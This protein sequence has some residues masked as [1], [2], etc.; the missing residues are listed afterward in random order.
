MMQY[1]VMVDLIRREARIYMPDGTP[2]LS[3][4][5]L[6]EEGDE[7][8]LTLMERADET[9][10][11]K[12]QDLQVAEVMMM[13]Q[14]GDDVETDDGMSCDSEEPCVQPI[15]LYPGAFENSRPVKEG[16][17]QWNKVQLERE[18]PDLAPLI[19]LLS[20]Q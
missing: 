16:S 20:E 10:K 5:A 11:K 2:E 3:V 17:H 13:E 9:P 1:N 12:K 4:A 15:P 19:D 14:D 18:L 7:I 8:L 6:S